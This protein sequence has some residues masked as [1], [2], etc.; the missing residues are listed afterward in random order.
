MNDR[1]NWNGQSLLYLIEHTM[2][3]SE[4]DKLRGTGRVNII[5]ISKPLI[6]Q[7]DRYPR[8]L[9]S[10]ISIQLR[11]ESIMDQYQIFGQSLRNKVQF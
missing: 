11:Q 7:D 1:Y 5:G 9:R 2:S 10:P 6:R 8:H 4:G 3:N